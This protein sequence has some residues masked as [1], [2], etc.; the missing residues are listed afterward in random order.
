MGLTLAI[1]LAQK[2]IKVQLF[3][4]RPTIKPTIGRMT[5]VY[6]SYRALSAFASVGVDVTKIPG[7]LPISGFDFINP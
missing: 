7:S 5:S 3:E 6:L 1:G 2:G 4:K